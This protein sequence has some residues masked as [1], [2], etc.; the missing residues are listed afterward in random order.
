LLTVLLALHLRLKRKHHAVIVVAE[1]AGQYLIKSDDSKEKDASGNM[2][3]KNIGPF[4]R[5]TL[6]EYFEKKDIRTNIKYI[7]PSYT[8]RSVP[9]NAMDSAYC[10]SLGQSAVHA[11][12]TG[13]TNMVVGSWNDHLIHVPISMAV[14]KRKR[15]NP[16]GRL[17]KT[18]MEATLQPSSMFDNAV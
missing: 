5:S 12:M 2:R 3:L 9:A 4:L 6:E 18:V 16:G 11:G 14:E 10:L 17:W 13:R 1:G 7:N 15:V 8:L